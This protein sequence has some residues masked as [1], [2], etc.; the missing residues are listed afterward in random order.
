MITA[1]TLMTLTMEKNWNFNT[2]DLS[3]D[4]KELLLEIKGRDTKISEDMYANIISDTGYEGLGL[5]CYLYKHRTYAQVTIAN[6]DKVKHPCGCDYTDNTI[7]DEAL[8]RLIVNGY[9][10]QQGD[11]YFFPKLVNILLYDSIFDLVYEFCKSKDRNQIPNL[12]FWINY[13]EG[14]TKV[15]EIYKDDTMKAFKVLSDKQKSLQ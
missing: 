4:T 15:K 7:V 9:I 1:R 13:A 3:D 10:V 5:Y 11:M 8:R 2:K 12:D 6:D 14:L